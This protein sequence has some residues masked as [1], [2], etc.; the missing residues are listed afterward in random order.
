[1]KF[2]EILL[3]LAALVLFAFIGCGDGGEVSDSEQPDADIAS[4]ESSEET[5]EA[6]DPATQSD[7]T[8]PE[9]FP[10][11]IPLYDIGNSAVLTAGETVMGETTTLVAILGTND[12]ISDVAADLTGRLEN[13]E[14]NVVIEDAT[15]ITG[16]SDDWAYIIYVDDGEI[17][18]YTTTVTYTLYSE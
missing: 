3:V 17:E 2:M 15:M 8:I 1:M 7:E 6:S 9:N 14:T 11:A 16:S 5:E 13:I 10:D 18:G 4:S 12:Q